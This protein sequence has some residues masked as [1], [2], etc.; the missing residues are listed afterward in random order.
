MLVDLETARRNLKQLDTSD[1]DNIVL[2]LR[3]ASAIVVDY[4]KLPAGVYEDADGNPTNVPV[5]VSAAVLLVLRSLYDEPDV[6]PINAAV[7]SVL[8]RSRDPALA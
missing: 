1:D 4:L 8:M 5:M 3:Q 2:L 7:R 6:D